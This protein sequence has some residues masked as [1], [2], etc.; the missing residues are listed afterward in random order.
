MNQRM[1]VVFLCTSVALFQTL[2]AAADPEIFT[3]SE[4]SSI[5]SIYFF[6]TPSLDQLTQL[7]QSFFALCTRLEQIILPETSDHLTSFFAQLKPQKIRVDEATDEVTTQFVEDGNHRLA[8]MTLADCNCIIKKKF[9][10]YSAPFRQKIFS[11]L[12]HLLSLLF[13]R[14]HLPG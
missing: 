6:N 7:H 8:E 11:G 9:R 4:P 14:G 13:F 3:D 10:E 5:V 12:E 1:K 2:F